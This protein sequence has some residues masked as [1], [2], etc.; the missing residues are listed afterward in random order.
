MKDDERREGFTND[1]KYTN[2]LLM[3]KL[4]GVPQGTGE[5]TA[6]EKI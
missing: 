1:L 6:V 2:C 3:I 5:S 4:R